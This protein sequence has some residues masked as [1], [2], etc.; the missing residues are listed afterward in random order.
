M[1]QKFKPFRIGIVGGM[2]PRT[3]IL[4]QQLIIEAT[5]ASKDQ[6]HLQVLCFT[7]PKIPDRTQS[8]EQ[9]DG[10]TYV[11]E[12]RKTA[13]QLVK[14]G[15]DIIA[16][17]CNTAHARIVK[18]QKNISV[19]ILNMP[20]CAIEKLRNDHPTVLRV[21]V[22]ATNGTMKAQIYEHALNEHGVTQIAPDSMDQASIMGLIYRIK[23]G[24]QTSVIDEMTHI[25]KRL[26]QR[27]ARAVILGCT[28]L[29]LFAP[30]L[31]QKLS[32][33]LI[34]PLKEVAKVLVLKGAR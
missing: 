16:I 9:D 2:G 34:D 5:P 8:L 27:G 13:R 4:L 10:R 29:S 33:P 1:S 14:V 6:D 31:Q 18:I 24:D 28:E 21:G 23:T 12:I 22:L 25:V 26:A 17:P 7:N 32:M 20:R 3:D 30:Q 19:P 11:Y 15:V